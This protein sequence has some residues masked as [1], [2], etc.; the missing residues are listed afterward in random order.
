MWTKTLRFGTLLLLQRLMRSAVVHW[1]P[2]AAGARR[3]TPARRLHS[4]AFGAITF[5][6]ESSRRSCEPCRGAKNIAFRAPLLPQN[7]RHRSMN[8]CHK[9]NTT[10]PLFSVA[11]VTGRGIVPAVDD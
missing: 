9:A 7:T 6:Y 8:Q 5:H 4:H 11:T 10:C 1:Q 2:P 3:V